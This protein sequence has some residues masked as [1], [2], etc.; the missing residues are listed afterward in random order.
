MERVN[1]IQSD[2]SPAIPPELEKLRFQVELEFLQMLA[3]PLYVQCE[4]P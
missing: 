1:T 4:W 2:A 3:N